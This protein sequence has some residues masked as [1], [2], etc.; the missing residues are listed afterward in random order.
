MKIKYKIPI[1]LIF[2][3]LL[4]TFILIFIRTNTNKSSPYKYES[5][6]IDNDTDTDN[7]Q[8]IEQQSN[9]YYKINTLKE[10]IND[11]YTNTYYMNNL[12]LLESIVYTKKYIKELNDIFTNKNYKFIKQEK[13]YKSK[14]DYYN[15]LENIY[16]YK[17]IPI[18]NKIDEALENNNINISSFYYNK[19]TLPPQHL[20]S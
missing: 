10:S 3:I 19:I 4:L 13:D 20:F 2:A 1:F 7:R 14:N 6:S 8:E 18:E 17:I 16:L 11:N 15:I 9:I 12:S 5:I